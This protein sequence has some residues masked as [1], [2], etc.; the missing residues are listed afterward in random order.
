MVKIGLVLIV[1]G[2]GSLVLQFLGFDVK[3]ED[4]LGGFKVWVGLISAA[5]GT[6]LLLAGFLGG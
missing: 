3:F 5:A 1:L 6:L 4:F 2:V